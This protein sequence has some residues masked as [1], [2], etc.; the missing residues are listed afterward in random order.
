MQL[1]EG[2]AGHVTPQY[3]FAEA[4]GC[5]FGGLYFGMGLVTLLLNI[6]FDHAPSW[7][8]ISA[9]VMVT[10]ALVVMECLRSRWSL[11]AC[12]SRLRP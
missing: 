5:A 4:M 9:A 8:P 3:T 12:I 6:K 7:Y 1:P 2:G 10:G 11:S